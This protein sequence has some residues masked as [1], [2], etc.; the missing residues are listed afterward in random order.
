[1]LGERQQTA[2]LLVGVRTATDWVLIL[3]TVLATLGIHELVH[4]AAYRLLGYQV[5]YGMSRHLLAVYAAAFDQ[6]Q[7][8]NHNL[9][10]ALAPLIVL[11]VILVP[12]LAIQSHT[13]V[14]VALAAL[15]MNTGGAVGDLYLAWRLLRL[16][17]TALLYDI[18]TETMLIFEPSAP[19]WRAGAHERDFNRWHPDPERSTPWAPQGLLPFDPAGE[20]RYRVDAWWRVGAG[21]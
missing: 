15:L 11:T 10:V 9:I 7:T 19:E 3:L 20:V 21:W 5:S 14:L 17:R 2:N 12:L 18:D 4:G 6:W 13:I 16:P 1:M 8:R